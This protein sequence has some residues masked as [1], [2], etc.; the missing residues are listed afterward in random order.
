M[1]VSIAAYGLKRTAGDGCVGKRLIF[2][3][4]GIVD[5]YGEISAV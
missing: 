3:N 2:T 1:V 4:G 5:V